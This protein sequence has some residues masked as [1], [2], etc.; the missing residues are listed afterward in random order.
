[1]PG[2]VNTGERVTSVVCVRKDGL[3][4]YINGKLMANWPTRFSDMGIEKAWQL[5]SLQLIGVGAMNSDTTFHKIELKEIAGTGAAY[6]A[7]NAGPRLDQSRM[8]PPGWQPLAAA[9]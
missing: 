5:P 9:A 7:P 4:A 1:M 3:R 6:Q 8:V 2:V